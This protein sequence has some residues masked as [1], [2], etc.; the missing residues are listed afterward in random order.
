MGL[1]AAVGAACSPTA[2]PDVTLQPG[3]RVQFAEDA[4]AEL[5]TAAI[6]GHVGSGQDDDCTTLM[7]PDSWE[8]PE[9]YRIV[10]L[11]AVGA[12]RVSTRYDGLPG[13]DGRPRATSVPPDTVGE[14]WTPLPIDAV[15]RRYAGCEPG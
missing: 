11:D 5:W 12:L 1:A 13:E 10:R 2:D 15:R 6:V 8:Q 3:A 9:R 7:V 4:A 14:G